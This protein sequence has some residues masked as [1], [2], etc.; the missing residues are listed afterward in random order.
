MSKSSLIKIWFALLAMLGISILLGE[1]VS[2]QL[3]T[4][5]I[6]VIASVKAFLVMRYYMGLR[7]EP[8]Y[9]TL[10]M[11]TALAFMVFLF[12]ALT[13]DIIYVYGN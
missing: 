8:K 6:F 3:A 11:L 4:I 5:L 13:P 1:K 9:V 12:F 2:P 10:A 7:H